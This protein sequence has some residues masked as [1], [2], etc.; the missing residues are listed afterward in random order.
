[1]TIGEALKKERKDLGLT[2]TEMAGN[3]LTKSFYSKVE[4]EQHEI[5]AIDLI[6]ILRLHDINV[7]Q[8]FNQIGNNQKIDDQK[9]SFKMYLSELHRAYYQKDLGQL[10]KLQEQLKEEVQTSE[11][12]NLETQAIVIKAYLT[13][14]LNMLTDKEKADIKKQIFKTK[15]WNENSLRLLAI[16]MPLFD[17]EDL[18][19]IINTIFNKYYSMRNISSIQ[20]ELVSAI[21][22]NYLGL[23]YREDN[24]DRKEVN[25]ALSILKQLSYEPKNCFAK[26]MEQYYTAQYNHDEKKA[27]KIRQFFIENDMGYYVGKD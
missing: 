17:L 13:H 22:V 15:D 10:S 24:K 27:E 2:Q 23:S 11:I 16:A 19:I 20:Q 8:F 21:A 3:V 18:K 6:K 14:S 5:K 7:S 12:L 26:I 9:Y 4:R 25:L 1:M